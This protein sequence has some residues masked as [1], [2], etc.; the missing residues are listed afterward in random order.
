MKTD[1][2]YELDGPLRL[3]EDSIGVFLRRGYRGLVCTSTSSPGPRPFL[4]DRETLR[5]RRG[6]LR[7]S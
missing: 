1:K 5:E 3:I 6:N 2:M 4:S 7:P